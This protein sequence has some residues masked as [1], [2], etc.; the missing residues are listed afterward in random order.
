MRSHL[1]FRF[2]LLPTLIHTFHSIPQVAVAR[3][4]YTMVKD[5][6]LC[7]SAKTLDLPYRTTMVA[8]LCTVLG[9]PVDSDPRC[10]YTHPVTGRQMKTMNEL[11]RHMADAHGG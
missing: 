5:S 11:Y 1:D 10:N 7:D 6:C 4:A 2:P 9:G 3:T 8:F